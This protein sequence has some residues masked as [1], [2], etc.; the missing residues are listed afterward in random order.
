MEKHRK[1]FTDNTTQTPSDAELAYLAANIRVAD[2]EE[3]IAA[4][5]GGTQLSPQRLY[6]IMKEEVAVSD[7]VLLVYEP[8]TRT[9]M[10]IAGVGAF[11]EYPHMG[12]VWLHAT[13]AIVKHKFAFLKAARYGLELFTKN[14]N[15]LS[16]STDE[17][18]TLHL[19]WLQWLGFVPLARHIYSD[20]TI[21]FVKC[22]LGGC[23]PPQDLAAG[24]AALCAKYPQ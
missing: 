21:P 6:Y 16:C 19:K 12:D 4:T 24:G 13:D 1:L 23:V 15:V 22:V 20:P 3:I 7:K 5:E 10:I 9:P 2:V 14:Y 8:N 11:G 18:N 17:R